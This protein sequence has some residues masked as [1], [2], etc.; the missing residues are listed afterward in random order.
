MSELSL[1]DLLGKTIL[2]GITYYTKD[3][4]FIEQKQYWGTVIEADE[5]QILFRQK[6]GE[7]FSLPPDLRSIKPAPKGEYKLRSTGEIVVDPDFTSVW[8]LIRNEDFEV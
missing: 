7:L 5:E 2:V 6:N 8:E 3:N 4:E 1:S